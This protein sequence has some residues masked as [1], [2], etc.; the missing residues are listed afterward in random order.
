MC[1]ITENVGASTSRNPKGLH[2]LYKENFTFILCHIH[3]SM[4][5]I[6]YIYL[7]NMIRFCGIWILSK[8]WYGDSTTAQ[9]G[10]A[11]TWNS[12]ISGAAHFINHL[13][14]GR[15]GLTMKRTTFW[16]IILCT[17]IEEHYCLRG[18]SANS[19]QSI[20]IVT[21]QKTVFFSL[22]FLFTYN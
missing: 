15:L 17:L 19:V 16:D 14:F 22:H 21:V 10:Q 12:T 9:V 4:Y 5:N 3:K 6:H 13:P 18:M 8:E 1:Q 2:G 20:Y 7:H 11:A